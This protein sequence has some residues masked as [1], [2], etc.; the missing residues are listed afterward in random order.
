MSIFDDAAR[1][2]DPPSRHRESRSWFLNSA[3]GAAS[4]RIRATLEEWYQHYPAAGRADLRGR[5]RSESKDVFDGA[6]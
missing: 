5:L 1:T 3:S 2:N 6:F 4:D